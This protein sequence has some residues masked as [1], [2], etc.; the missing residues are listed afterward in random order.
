MVM[1][2]CQCE[3]PPFA[4]LCTSQSRVLAVA[5]VWLT[6]GAAGSQVRGQFQL[7]TLPDTCQAPEEGARGGT[8]SPLRSSE[9]ST[10]ATRTEHLVE[11]GLVM[12]EAAWGEGYW[13]SLIEAPTRVADSENPS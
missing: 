9:A 10:H 6:S 7:S 3:T 11:A 4:A 5:K 13:D 8:T 2:A 1:V 12:A